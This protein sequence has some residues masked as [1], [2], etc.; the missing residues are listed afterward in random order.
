MQFVAPDSFN[1][2]LSI[3]F[4]VGIVVGGIATLSGA[5]YGAL[6]IQFVPNFADEISKA[7]PWAIYGLVLLVF[8]Y[9]MPGGVAWMLVWLRQR[10]LPSR[11]ATPPRG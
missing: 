3:S 9:L 8:I 6:F 11:P 7:A 5:I 10:V 4:V 1:S 2:F